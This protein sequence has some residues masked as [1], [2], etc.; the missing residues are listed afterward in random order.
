MR[1]YSYLVNVVAV[2]RP[3]VLK[4]TTRLAI[5]AETCFLSTSIRATEFMIIFTN[6]RITRGFH[7]VVIVVNTSRLLV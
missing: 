5:C 7:L 1:N 2:P 6:T 4:I 3:R